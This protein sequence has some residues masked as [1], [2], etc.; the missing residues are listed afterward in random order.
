MSQPS[1]AANGALIQVTG[2]TL[3]VGGGGASRAVSATTPNLV[4]T[5]PALA[6]YSAAPS[7]DSTGDVKFDI[8]G[9]TLSPTGSEAGFTATFT[10]TI[11]YVQQPN[12]RTALAPG[13]V[14]F[15]VRPGTTHRHHR[16]R[17]KEDK[18]LPRARRPN[19]RSNEAL[20]HAADRRRAS[21]DPARH[22]HPRSDLSAARRNRHS[23]RHESLPVSR[24]VFGTRSVRPCST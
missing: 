13:S 5:Y 17:G 14:S 7:V 23:H 24:P 6:T 10:A 20:R 19:G 2:A 12:S 9:Q 18:C 1:C 11:N 8:P 15:S 4:T 16:A 3:T 21:R 22:A